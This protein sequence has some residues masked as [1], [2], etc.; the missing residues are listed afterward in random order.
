MI[1]NVT[2]QQLE[3]CIKQGKYYYPAVKHYHN[4]AIVQCDRCLRTNLKCCIG[5]QQI[6]LCLS[7]AQLISMN[8][9]YPQPSPIGI[10]FTPQMNFVRQTF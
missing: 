7:C 9:K 10:E 4:G 2:L 1:E 3:N 6:D 5:H 8:I